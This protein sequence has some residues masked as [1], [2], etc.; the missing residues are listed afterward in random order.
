MNELEQAR[1]Q[2]NEI[3]KKMAEL[4]EARMEATKLVASYKKA[5]ALPI[6]DET[7]ERTVVENNARMIKDPTIREYYVNFLKNNMALSKRYQTRLMEGMKVAYCG[8]EGAFAHI[9]S[10]KMFPSAEKIAFASFEE[11]YKAV[12]DGICDACV[13]PVEN[14]YAGDVGTVMDLIF[15]GS[16]HINQMLDL[17]VIHHLIGIKGATCATVK[18]VLSHPQALSQCH[19]YLTSHHFEEVEY[20]NTALAAK[21]VARLNDVSVAAIASDV[22]ASL[23]GLTIIES[24]INTARNNT[25]RFAAFSRVDSLTS[26]NA[27]MGEHFILV[28]TVANEAGALAQTLNIIGAHGFNMRN[29]RSRPMKELMWNYYFYVELEGNVNSEEGMDM[30][31]E[32]GSICDR[33]KLVGTYYTDLKK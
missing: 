26:S 6:V 1:K 14:S 18:K 12:E 30:L 11:A 27:L 3:D 25:T 2:I 4:F 33:L 20:P 21:E 7:R 13:L 28:F 22:T 19:S 29:L 32:L 31:R 10:I 23:Y 24:D 9:A 5:H 15:S 16:L 8:V 17:D